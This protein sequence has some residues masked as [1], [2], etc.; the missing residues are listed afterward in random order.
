MIV[1]RF[2]FLSEKCCDNCCGE[3]ISLVQSHIIYEISRRN[4]HSMQEIAGSLG[5]DT[6]T[7]SRQIKTLVEEGIVYK[8]SHPADNRVSILSLTDKGRNIEDKIN[9]EMNSYLSTILGNLSDY[10]R[11]SVIRSIKLLEEAMKNAE[12]LC[13]PPK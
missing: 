13:C 6:T 3:N 8:K 7:F 10:E 12:N 4:D 1:R 9:S 2:G 11:D 5:I